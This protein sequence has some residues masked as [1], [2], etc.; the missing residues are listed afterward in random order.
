MWYRGQEDI[1]DG[2]VDDLCGT[3][4]RGMRTMAM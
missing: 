2:N 3:N 4:D 1:D